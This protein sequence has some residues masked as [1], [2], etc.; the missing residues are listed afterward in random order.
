MRKM[1]FFI[2]K[3]CL[4]LQV[5]LISS[6]GGGSNGGTRNIGPTVTVINPGLIEERAEVTLS[7]TAGDV[8]G[9]IREIRWQQTSGP[10]IN[11]TYSGESATF[12]APEVEADTDFSF[13]I[14]AVDN[15]GAVAATDLYGTIINVNRAPEAIENTLQLAKNTSVEFS[16]SAS[17]PDNDQ[18]TYQV[19]QMPQFGVLETLD[20]SNINYRYTPNLD[21]LTNDEITFE[22][23]DGALSVTAKVY[24]ELY[25]PTTFKNLVISEVSSSSGLYDNR[26]IE[27]YNGTGRSIQLADYSL[28][29]ALVNQADLSKAGTATF[30]LPSAILENNSYMLVQFALSNHIWHSVIAQEGKLLVIGNSNEPEQPNWDHSGFIELLDNNQTF[31]VDFV[32]FGNSIQTPLNSDEWVNGG[33]IQNFISDKSLIRSVMVPDSNSFSDWRHSIVAT[34]GVANLVDN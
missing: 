25:E 11:F 15:V 30:S 23:S 31:T 13:M 29:T 26:W 1:S 9:S 20:S 16:L 4:I 14:T 28:K 6:C 17:D 3:L 10:R 8:D 5:I 7:V 12:I 18:L 32:K 27:L 22:V 19:T 33:E 34:P 21:S 24:F 2:F